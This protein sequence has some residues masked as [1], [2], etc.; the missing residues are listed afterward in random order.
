MLRSTPCGRGGFACGSS[1]L[2]MRS[3][4]SPKLSNA[5]APRLV[6][7]LNICWPDWPDCTRRFHACSRRGKMPSDWRNRARRLLSELVAADAADVLHRR[8]S[9]GSASGSPECC[10]CRR[11]GPRSESSASSTS[12]WPGN[13]AAAAASSGAASAVKLQ[14]LARLCRPLGAV[15]QAVAARPHGVVRFRQVRHDK[16]AAVVGDDALDVATGRSRVSAMTQTPASGPSGPVTTPPMSSGSIATSAAACSARETEAD[17]AAMARA[18]L[19][20]AETSTYRLRI[21]P[22]LKGVTARCVTRSGDQ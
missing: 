21:W 17:A 19:N 9:T 6:N 15:D 13:S 20:P 22:L 3:V 8:R 11:I 16:P 4:Q 18:T 1:P 10:S 7:W 5:S 14:L 12:R 2:A